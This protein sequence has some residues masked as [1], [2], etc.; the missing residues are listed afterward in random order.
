MWPSQ[1]DDVMQ[2]DSQKHI[3]YDDKEENRTPFFSNMR[4]P[5]DPSKLGQQIELQC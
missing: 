3:R 2:R 5:Q 4:V 1:N